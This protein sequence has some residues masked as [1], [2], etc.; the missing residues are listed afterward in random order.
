MLPP[1]PSTYC[2]CQSFLPTAQ[3]SRLM[4]SA[5]AEKKMRLAGVSG[6]AAEGDDAPPLETETPLAWSDS[7]AEG[8]RMV[9]ADTRNSLAEK[10]ERSASST[11][12]WVM[13]LSVARSIALLIRGSSGRRRRGQC[14]AA[15]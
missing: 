6:P 1:L 4:V 14:G 10:P 13:T 12:L 3:I 2:R 5:S 15:G 7:R 8:V 11:S 9:V